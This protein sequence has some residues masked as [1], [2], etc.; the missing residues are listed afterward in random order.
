MDSNV[1]RAVDSSTIRRA[2]DGDP[3]ARTA[4]ASWAYDELRTFFA[5]IFKQ[6]ELASELIQKAV[7]QILGKL[8]LAP[9]D[10][11]LF[12]G[13]VRGLGGL[14]ARG[15]T[16]D[17]GRELARF[18]D[19]DVAHVPAESTSATLFGPLLQ[20]ERRQLVIEHAQLLRPAHRAALL[21][22]LDGGDYKSL[23][24]SEGIL[25]TTAASRIS[26]ATMKVGRSIEAARRTPPPYRTRP[27]RE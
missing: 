15:S 25:E 4:L 6:P 8:S 10:P 17:R 3:R 20:E 19:R 9:D 16:R 2:R 7:S 5:S 24:A 1:R 18:T 11:D 21:H 13:F 27:V 14:T 26:F 23:A 22:V 12:R